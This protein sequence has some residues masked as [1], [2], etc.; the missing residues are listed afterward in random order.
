ML[1]KYFK[2]HWILTGLLCVG[3]A[4]PLWP[5]SVEAN[6]QR[7]NAAV[8]SKRKTPQRTAKSSRANRP[9]PLAKKPAQAASAWKCPPMVPGPEKD[10]TP[11]A[12][13]VHLMLKTGE[14]K[15]YV[16]R[17]QKLLY[18]YTVAVGK[19][20]CETPTGD[21]QVM[22]MEKN[23]GW[24]N[25]K[26][27]EVMPPGPD[28]PLGERWIGF[29]TDNKDEIGFHGTTNLGSLG[30]AASHGCVRLSNANV[31]VLYKLVKVGTVVRVR[32]S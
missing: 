31:K 24:T 6:N 18:T 10:F 8:S 25:F 28:N 26:T 15:L 29:W 32:S 30:K 27:G 7:S 19:K 12:D 9:Q 4:A 2:H 5:T 16:Y 17:G 3:M 13:E 22:Q 14:R 1:Q 11:Q 21:W 20:G 23:P